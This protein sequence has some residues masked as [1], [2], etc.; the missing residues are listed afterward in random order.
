MK[1]IFVLILIFWIGFGHGQRTFNVL[2]YGA[3]GDGKTDD[4]KAFL[5]AWGELCGAADEPNGMPTLVIPEMKAFLL[6]PI[7][8]RGPCNSDGVHVQI[9]GKLVAPKMLDGWTECESDS[10]WLQFK[11]VGNLVVDGS[12][13][14][15]GQ[16]SS[17][18]TTP[19]Q[20]DRLSRKLMMNKQN[21]KAPDALHFHGCDNLKLSGLTHLNSARAHIAISGCNNVYVSHLTITAPEDSPNTD[22]IDISNSRNV[23]IQH[24]AIG[25]GDD[26]I[27]INGGCSDLNIAN[28][29]CGPGHGIS[30][31]SLGANGALE[32]VQN[33][34]V[35][36]SSFSGTTNGARIKTWQG[37]S[38]Y[39][40]NITFEK[41]TLD[42][43]KNPIIIDQ[44]YCNNDHNCKSQ[45]SALLVEDV[46]YIDFEGTS[47][48]EEAIKL[49]CDQ[50]SGCRN[51]IMDRIKITSAVPDKKIY[52]SCNNAIGTSIGTIVPNVP[53]LKSGTEPTTSPPAMPLPT[54]P[55]PATPPP[56]PPLPVMPPPS[57]PV[58][59]M[60]PPVPV[61]PPP[62]LPVPV[63]PPPSP[64][65]PIMPPPVPVMPPPSPPVPVIP[66]PS[67]PVPVIPPPSPPELVMPPPSP[68]LPAAPPLVLILPVTP[69]P[70]PPLP[71]TPPPLPATPH[72]SPL[73]PATPPQSLPLPA[74]SPQSPPLP[75]T[76]PQSPPL[77]ATPPQSPPL[78]ATP[79]S[80][81]PL[82]ATPPPLQVMPPPLLNRPRPT[83]PLPTTPPA[84][85]LLTPL[86]PLVPTPP[87]PTPPPI[88]QMSFTGEPGVP[89]IYFTPGAS[90]ATKLHKKHY[91]WCQLL[92]VYVLTRLLFG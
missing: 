40:K 73:L 4:S 6:Q 71:D 88:P 10:D 48:N 62:S 24:S 60:P 38:G 12:G 33:V 61:M 23:F 32:T 39:A 36:D 54:V 58:P 21:C 64:P 63:M 67:P 92:I 90:S 31:G 35:R 57:P 51:I 18:W 75:A 30:V 8:F 34:Y 55:L 72:P 87:P 85:P 1:K 80:S 7:K 19:N 5:K 69:P 45:A 52:A 74:T 14:I 91:I 86:A 25:T 82:P 44:F 78:P 77:P 26:C 68:P 13:E 17:W 20:Y 84:V 43:A 59:V 83:L 41:I 42:A 66:P 47:A 50:N 28:I 9:M 15:D 49:D 27:A 11:D 3:T 70:A 56:S 37:G 22:G 29:A 2:D 76:P 65:V 53:C 81:P 89:D 79:P 46:K 16:G